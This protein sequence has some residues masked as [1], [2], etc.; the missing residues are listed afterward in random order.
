MIA[1]PLYYTSLM[2]ETAHIF[3]PH[4]DSLAERIK[5][6]QSVVNLLYSTEHSFEAL[7]NEKIEDT[8]HIGTKEEVQE[9]Y[10]VARNSLSIALNKI[11]EQEMQ[12]ALEK[13]LITKTQATEFI[14]FTRQHDMTH[15]RSTKRS[16]HS[17]S[18][19]QKQ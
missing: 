6:Y 4:D 11:S 2:T 9:A 7:K 17:N 19:S 14:Q 10:D 12:Q 13:G 16:T 1:L 5:A 18:Q 8:Y 15:F 3:T